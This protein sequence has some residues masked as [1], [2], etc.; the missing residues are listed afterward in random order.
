MIKSFQIQEGIVMSKYITHGK[1]GS[2]ANRGC[3]CLDCTKA[4][5]AYAQEGRNIT[6]ENEKQ[7]VQFFTLWDHTSHNDGSSDD[8][9]RFVGALTIF[10]D[11][12]TAL[13]KGDYS[14]EEA[15]AVITS[16][17]N[18]TEEA[19]GYRWVDDTESAG[20]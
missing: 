8:G 11:G 1:N 6:M 12:T 20:L 17:Q 5:N 4:H 2:Y 3:R 13:S 18:G 15:W 10:T 14:L 9:S 16:R 19:G 7:I